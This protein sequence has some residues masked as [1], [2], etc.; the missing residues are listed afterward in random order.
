M[1][2]EP[3]C[4]FYP[5]ATSQNEIGETIIEWRGEIV[6][7]VVVKPKSTSEQ[8]AKK[9]EQDGGKRPDGVRI[10]YQLAFPKTYER[11]VTGCKV[12]LL[13]RGMSADEPQSA[14]DVEGWCNRYRVCP[15]LWNMK[16]EVGIHE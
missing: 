11:D 15:T 2:G 12:A 4:V 14:Y 1:L 3:V 9:E 10:L 5:A 7:N 13:D 6:D 8:A 16:C